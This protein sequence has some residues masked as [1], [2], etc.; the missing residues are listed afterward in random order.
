MAQESLTVALLQ[1]PLVWKNAQANRD[2]I[3]KQLEIL[4][5]EVDLVV[6]PEMFNTGFTMEVEGV[7]E[8]MNGPTIAW[9]ES[10]SRAKGIAICGSIIIEENG[11]Y[12][13]R[14]VFVENGSLVSTYDKRHL[15]RMADEHL[16]FEA[17]AADGVH[18]FKGWN[19][20]NRV[21]YDLRF[22]VWSRSNAVDLQI[23]V[24][25]WPT[26]RIE[27][28]SKLLMAR[29][30]ENQCYVVG[31]NRI[32][33]DENGKQYNGR[34]IVIDPKGHALTPEEND[35][36]GWIVA[37]LNLED[38]ESFREKFPLKLDADEFSIDL[39]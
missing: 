23:Y 31:V 35:H 29:A 4:G 3:E 37:E 28:W 17:G 39:S 32:G 24:A 9:M 10:T 18:T 13:N 12:F 34:S 26:P 2:A 25:N 20:M 19:I 15:F 14:F 33:T 8:K 7:S 22:P 1:I 36:E 16:T 21:C 30:I 27:A 6:L 11:K 38:L 5:S